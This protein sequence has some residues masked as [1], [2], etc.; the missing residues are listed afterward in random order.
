MMN[1][2]VLTNLRR[3]VSLIIAV[4]IYYIIHEGSHLIFA[5]RFG[6]FEK[7]NFLGLGVQIA[8]NDTLLSNL[9]LA[10]FCV[11]GSIAT[12]IFAYIL[13]ALTNRIVNVKNKYF[14]AI[15]YYT[16]LSM[17][18]IDPIYLSFLYRFFGGGDMNGIKLFG[19]PEIVLQVIYGIIGIINLIVF[20]K[21]VYP[22]YKKAFK[23]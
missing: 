19:I 13:V 4:L 20:I 17:L 5:L 23:I 14:K 8:I 18:L 2:K 7:I 21:Y 15:G 12:L 6:A 10:I 22:K 11:V 16:T 9:Q 3:W 1:N